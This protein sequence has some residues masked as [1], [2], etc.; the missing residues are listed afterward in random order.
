MRCWSTWEDEIQKSVVHSFGKT[1]HPT[2]PLLL[3]LHLS[4]IRISIREPIVK[5]LAQI[6]RKTSPIAVPPNTHQ[7]V[8]STSHTERTNN[9]HHPLRVLSEGEGKT[10]GPNCKITASSRDVSSA[11]RALHW[12][13]SFGTGSPFEIYATKIKQIRLW[14]PYEMQGTIDDDDGLLIVLFVF[15][16]DCIW[17]S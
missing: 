2:S 17:A 4:A 9:Y 10:Y 3:V 5:D 13:E 15:L 1:F 11:L 7:A 14:H 8:R 6:P 12:W 16:N